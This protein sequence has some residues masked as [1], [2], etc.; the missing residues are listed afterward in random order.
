MELPDPF[1][2]WCRRLK[3]S[4]A[5]AFEE[6]FRATHGPLLRYACGFTNDEA[7]AADLVQE[8]YV[9][10]WERRALLDPERSL[11]ALLYRMTRNLA[12][13]YRRDRALH[14]AKHQLMDT[15]HAARPPSPESVVDSTLLKH[16]LQAWI[17]ELPERQ[18]EALM[19]SR[20]DGLSHEEIASVMEV[21]PRTVN[22][23]LVK[24][25]KHLRERIRTYE[26]SLLLEA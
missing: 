19:L 24:A 14:A 5:G 21:S 9:K 20:F 1:S 7:V 4:E 16:R 26:P 10:V 15:D 25:L 22:N 6:L 3:A 12:L 8:V 2:A 11:Q 13:N 18:R 23:H 17:D